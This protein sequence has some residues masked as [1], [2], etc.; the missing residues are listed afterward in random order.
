MGAVG[1]FGCL[2]S[3]LLRVASSLFR[4]GAELTNST[5][6]PEDHHLLL[7]R[8]LDAVSKKPP[9]PIWTGET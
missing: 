1:L 9:L 2:S 7:I 3:S 6:P 8:T 4:R 5:L